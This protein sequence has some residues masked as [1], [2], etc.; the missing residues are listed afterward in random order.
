MKK[1]NEIYNEVKQTK[2]SGKEMKCMPLEE[3]YDE[4][5]RLCKV[6]LEGSREELI[7]EYEKQ[8]EELEKCLKEHGMTM[9]DIK[10][11][12]DNDEDDYDDDE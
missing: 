10:N 4:H 7:S 1:I 6:L 3:F 11:D 5:L 2:V 12:N 9:E 8:H